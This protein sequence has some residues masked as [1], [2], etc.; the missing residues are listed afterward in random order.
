[1]Q[2]DA[3]IHI[4]PVWQGGKASRVT[5]NRSELWHILNIYGRMVAAG[6]WRDYAIDMLPDAAIFSVYR[7]ASEFPRYRI[8]KCPQ[9]ARK[10]G[11]W[12][13][14]APD[15]RIVKRGHSLKNLLRLFDN[16]LLRLV[17]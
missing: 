17:D 2:D 1:M 5:F 9:F 7:R 16:K 13:V 6:M 14:V 15:G 12:S 10:Q 8:I 3:P 4:L 11:A